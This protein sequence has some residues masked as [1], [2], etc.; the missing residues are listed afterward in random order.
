MEKYTGGLQG[1]EEYY[2]SHG[3]DPRPSRHTYMYVNLAKAE[4][5]KF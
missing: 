5:Q 4:P 1:G 3:D 2:Q